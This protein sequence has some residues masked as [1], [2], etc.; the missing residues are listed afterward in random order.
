MRYA[1]PLKRRA[2]GE[3]DI[4]TIVPH[5]LEYLEVMQVEFGRLVPKNETGGEVKS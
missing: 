1:A 4:F 3:R 2:G 5:T